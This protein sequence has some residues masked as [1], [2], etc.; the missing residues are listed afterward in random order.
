MN[1][2]HFG[3]NL[4]VDLDTR[5]PSSQLFLLVKASPI[6][7]HSLEDEHNYASYYQFKK[8][9]DHH[10]VVVTSEHLSPG[11]WYIGVCNYVQEVALFD[12]KRTVVHSREPSPD[13]AAYTVVATL[14]STKDKPQ[15]SNCGPD[16]QHHEKER[17]V[18]L[19][20]HKSMAM[21]KRG[22][23]SADI[24]AK[25]ASCPDAGAVY[26]ADK[27]RTQEC[28]SNAPVRTSQRAKK[29]THSEVRERS[30]DMGSK[31]AEEEE[32]RML[33]ET[34]SG[35]AKEGGDDRAETLFWAVRAEALEKELEKVREEME[36]VKGELTGVLSHTTPTPSFNP[37]L[38]PLSQLHED[39]HDELSSEEQP[40]LY[41]AGHPAAGR[42]RRRLSALPGEHVCM[43]ECFL[44]LLWVADFDV[45]CCVQC[46][47]L[48]LRWCRR[49]C[50]REERCATKWVS[51]LGVCVLVFYCQARSLPLSSSSSVRGNWR[52]REKSFLHLLSRTT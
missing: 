22:F 24:D 35:G 43:C 11:R 12:D 45:Y 14:N 39:D 48:C 9:G 40:I 31:R 29:V 10:G 17:K 25:S 1:V 51:A 8:Q 44:L 41:T 27:D 26:A 42:R 36:I 46:Q 2:T 13:D 37:P 28:R 34:G 5:T 50:F 23:V 19:S 30:K 32:R 49:H 33:G 6:L 47:L 18:L 3:Y 4:V 15:P 7:R 16:C 52:E 20:K 21:E 38:P